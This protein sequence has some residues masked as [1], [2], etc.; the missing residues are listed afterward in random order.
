MIQKCKNDRLLAAAREAESARD[1]VGAA[2]YY[3]SAG[4]CARAAGCRERAV[5]AAVRAA[6]PT[7]RRIPRH[8]G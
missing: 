8:Q 7:A 6:T 4:M 3:A 5:V 2:I 1:W